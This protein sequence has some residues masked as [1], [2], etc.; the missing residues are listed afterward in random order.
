[1]SDIV[2]SSEFSEENQFAGKIYT[3]PGPYNFTVPE[4]TNS[5]YL[6]GGAYVEIPARKDVLNNDFT[7][8]LWANSA[9]NDITVSC[10]IVSWVNNHS[11]IPTNGILIYKLPLS[12][13]IAVKIFDSNIQLVQQ[14]GTYKSNTW[15]H[16]ALVRCDNLI[17]LYVDGDEVDSVI[18]SGEINVASS[19]CRIGYGHETLNTFPFFLGHISNFRIVKDTAVYHSYEFELPSKL[20]PDT[21]I[22]S[23]YNNTTLLLHMNGSDNGTIFT[24]SSTFE[25]TIINNGAITK[26]NQYKFNGSS[27]YF[28]DASSLQTTN[29]STISSAEFDGTTS[30]DA[31]LIELSADYTVECWVYLTNQISNPCIIGYADDGINTQLIRILNGKLYYYSDGISIIGSTT[32]ALNK[33][34]HLA[35]TKSNDTVR[36][37]VNGVLNG[38]AIKVSSDFVKYIGKLGTTSSGTLMYP[39]MGNV[40]NV[41]VVNGTALY[42]SSFI[43][44]MMP[45]NSVTDTVLLTAQHP[46]LFVDNSPYKNTVT[47]NTTSVTA[48]LYPFSNTAFDFGVEDFTIECWVFLSFNDAQCRNVFSIRYNES[49]QTL[50]MRLNNSEFGNQFA[51]CTDSTTTSEVYLTDKVRPGIWHKSWNFVSMQRRSGVFTCYI[52]GI[53]QSIRT[54]GSNTWSKSVANTRNYVGGDN[55]T[56][57][58]GWIGYLQDFRITRGVAR[59]NGTFTPSTHHLSPIFNTYSLTSQYSVSD[60]NSGNNITLKNINAVS[61]AKSPFSTDLNIDYLVVGGGGGGGS[62]LKDVGGGG[63]GGIVLFGNTDISSGNYSALVAGSSNADT[64]GNYSLFDS[65]VALGGGSGGNGPF[66]AGGNG[67]NGGGGAASYL[68]SGSEGQSTLAQGFSG[69]DGTSAISNTSKKYIGGGGGGSAERGY[70]GVESGHG[71]SGVASAI[72][73]TLKYYGGGG[74]GASFYTY[75]NSPAKG[76]L[77]GGGNGGLTDL[78][79]QNGQ[80]STGGGGGGGY[81]AG[82]TGGSGIVVIKYNNKITDSIYDKPG[83]FKYVV[84]DG[85]FNVSVLCVGAGGGYIA[86]ESS[87]FGNIVVATG[88]G[89]GDGASG[90][91]ATAGA[92]GVGGSAGNWNGAKGGGGGNRAPGG[93]AAGGSSDDFKIAGGGGGGVSLY[94]FNISGIGGSLGGSNGINGGGGGGG[95]QNSYGAGGFGGSGGGMSNKIGTDGSDI[96]SWHYS[97]PGGK[98]GGGQGGS[99]R[100][101]HGAGG[102]TAWSNNISVVPGQEIIVI[103][104]SPG[105][106]AGRG[107]VRIISGYGRNFPNNAI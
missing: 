78:S 70:S 8:E 71:G 34:C 16:I 91:F 54:F 29:L 48:N 94:G 38:S 21:P 6:N 88:G 18:Y 44:S 76:G 87:S 97:S 2:I 80:A 66:N 75:A 14:T 13:N 47:R 15:H 45:L 42:T 63:G 79:P 23:Y 59:Y 35:V 37:F 10:G 20:L 106:A 105:G 40:S 61:A 92:G 82:G 84:P 5:I 1:M 58:N 46:N 72:T 11:Q 101:S 81:Q 57:G 28:N 26:T 83:T 90:G 12:D 31:D 22:D 62:G 36:I 60:D 67:G 25:K 107:A 74:G 50:G 27:G 102:G 85:V 52:N 17:T 55:L 93:G 51:F 30:M 69:G 73:G 24:D 98:Y 7:I 68:E 39:L 86:G 4:R 64:P 56:I 95:Y 32:I 77:G 41:R 96:T 100:G 99:Y 33:W 19:T 103:V 3:T 43:P 89:A 104:G 53:Q 65:Y 49:G 9:L